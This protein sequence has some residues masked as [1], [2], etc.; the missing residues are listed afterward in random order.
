MSRFK[1]KLLFISLVLLVCLTL[2]VASASDV[3]DTSN[4]TVDNDDDVILKSDDADLDILSDPTGSFNDLNTTINDASEGSEITLRGDY[5]FNPETDYNYI[6]GIVINKTLTIN[7]NGY[8]IDAG[9]SARIF[10][11]AADGVVL[12]NIKFVNGNSTNSISTRGGAIYW[13]GDSGQIDKCTFINNT[14]NVA[15][16]IWWEGCNAILNDSIFMNN[17]A[18][19]EAGAIYLNNTGAVVDSCSF[20]NNTAGT[21]GGAFILWFSTSNTIGNNFTVV[22]SNFTNNHALTGSYGALYTSCY[23]TLIDNCNFINNTASSNSGAIQ[24]SGNSGTLSQ[25]YFYKEK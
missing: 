3:D 17:S 4:L 16:A 7:G 20:I 22:N 6:D 10:N 12:K 9:G 21:N 2:S 24:W 15:G 19:G 11:I 5:E 1:N 14:G 13:S 25:S 18:V 8:T 23:N